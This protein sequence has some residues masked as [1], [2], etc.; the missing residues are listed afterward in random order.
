MPYDG[1]F[2][3]TRRSEETF[4][5]NIHGRQANISIHRLKPAYILGKKPDDERRATITDDTQSHQHPALQD[6]DTSEKIW[7]TCA[8]WRSPS[9]R[10][11]VICMIHFITGTQYDS[12]PHFKVSH[13]SFLQ[14]SLYCYRATL[15]TSFEW[16][17]AY[18][19][20]LLLGRIANE[21][22]HRPRLLRAN[23]KE[24]AT[25]N[26]SEKWRPGARANAR[27]R[28]REPLWTSIS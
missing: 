9:I 11:R 2:P 19:S 14:R 26:R 15:D 27:I 22:G 25:E 10:F 13:R 18:A 24:S 20:F 21:D 3:N 8:N 16:T 6:D 17:V 4:L 28:H 5:V 12:T 7:E 23:Q 1:P